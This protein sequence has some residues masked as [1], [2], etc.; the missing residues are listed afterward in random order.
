[1]PPAY[2]RVLWFDRD[3]EA[4]GGKE[5]IRGSSVRSIFDSSTEIIKLSVQELAGTGFRL[6]KSYVV[7]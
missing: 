2:S 7:Y 6:S 1:M 3:L 4:F 5:E